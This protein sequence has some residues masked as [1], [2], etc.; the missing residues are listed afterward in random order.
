M[1]NQPD[2]EPGRLVREAAPF[3]AW[4][5]CHRGWLAIGGGRSKAE[6]AS[7]D[8]CHVVLPRGETPTDEHRPRYEYRVDRRNVADVG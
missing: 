3:I 6:A 8:D 4:H 1:P 2:F 5:F 7:F